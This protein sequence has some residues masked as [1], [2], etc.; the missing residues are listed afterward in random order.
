MLPFSPMFKLH[1]QES[2]PVRGAPGL[3]LWKVCLL[4]RVLTLSCH[5]LKDTRGAI[6]SRVSDVLLKQQVHL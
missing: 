1:S 3:L 4:E 6:K 2:Q 5:L